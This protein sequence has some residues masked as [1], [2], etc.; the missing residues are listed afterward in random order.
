M[1]CVEFFKI[2]NE[3][4]YNQQDPFKTNLPFK[5]DVFDHILN[6]SMDKSIDNYSKISKRKSEEDNWWLKNRSL[7][8]Q[9]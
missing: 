9:W 5:Q 2:K 3:K 7:K 8:S 4:Y 1:T 6:E